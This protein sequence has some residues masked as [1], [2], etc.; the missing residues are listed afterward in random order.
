MAKELTMFRIT[1]VFR[2]DKPPI[3]PLPF[4]PKLRELSNPAPM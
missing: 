2:K 4:N 3:P 1:A